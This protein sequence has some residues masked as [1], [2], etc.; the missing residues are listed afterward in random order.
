MLLVEKN[1]DVFKQATVGSY[2]WTNLEN[3]YLG[4]APF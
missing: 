1:T 3:I 2:G 4:I